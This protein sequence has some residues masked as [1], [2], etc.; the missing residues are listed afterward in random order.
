[1]QRTAALEA[2]EGIPLSGEIIAEN[3]PF[4]TFLTAYPGEHLEWFNG[5][6]IRMPGIDE[7]HDALTG[8]FRILL[9]IY[10]EL[11][12]GGRVL[13]DPMIMRARI[14]L[15]ARAPDLQVLLPVNLHLLRQNRVAGAAD[16][17]IEVISPESQRRDRVEKFAEYERAGIKEYWLF[18]HHFEEALF[19][20]LDAQ[21]KYVRADLDEAGVYHSIVLERLLLPVALLWKEK[22]PTVAEI[23][24]M[25]DAMLAP[26]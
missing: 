15:P 2:I 26:E 18:D 12:G 19:Y 16:L 6:I 5:Y 23:T 9:T 17:V 4:E 25:V 24:R 8:F 14:D 1:M 7:R 21:G 13:Q 10:L 3:V 11:T 22:L 20:Q